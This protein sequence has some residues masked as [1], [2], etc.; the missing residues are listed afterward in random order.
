MKRLLPRLVIAL[1]TF[2]IGVCFSVLLAIYQEPAEVSVPAV[3]EMSPAVPHR[4]PG[5]AECMFSAETYSWHMRVDDPPGWSP[6]FIT[7]PNNP[8]EL[9]GD[10]AYVIPAQIVRLC[11]EWDGR[12][13]IFEWLRERGARDAPD[14]PPNKGMNRTRNQRD[15]HQ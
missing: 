12:G 7:G 9:K 11:A 5:V 10:P 6:I 4:R 1:V 13:N 8:C 2:S 14:V 3:P 15:S